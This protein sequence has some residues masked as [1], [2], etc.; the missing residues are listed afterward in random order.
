M[1]DEIV[2]KNFMALN[3]FM[4]DQRNEVDALKTKLSD[5]DKEIAGLRADIAGLSSRVNLMFAKTMGTGP[6]GG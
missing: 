5:K 3:Q 1:N 4:K 6:T 2:V